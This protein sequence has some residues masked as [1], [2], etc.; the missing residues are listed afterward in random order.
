MGVPLEF[1][2][3]NPPFSALSDW[4]HARRMRRGYEAE[5]EEEESGS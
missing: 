3:L 4:W 1:D 2:V 5:D